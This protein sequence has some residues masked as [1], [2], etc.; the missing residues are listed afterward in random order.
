MS[1]LDRIDLENARV[2]PFVAGR[3]RSQRRQEVRTAS[4]A[5]GWLHAWRRRREFKRLATQL[6]TYDDHKLDDIGYSRQDLLAAI[7]L[8]LKVDAQ[9]LVTFWR[10]R[11]LRQQYR[12]QR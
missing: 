11:R 8:P 2:T 6:L 7:D 9:R 12:A 1:K 4:A 3:T 5:N 10:E